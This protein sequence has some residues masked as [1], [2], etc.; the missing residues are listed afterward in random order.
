MSQKGC[1]LIYFCISHIQGSVA[2]CFRSLVDV[3]DLG[4][5]APQALAKSRRQSEPRKC[6]M[7]S[8][9]ANK[10]KFSFKT[11]QASLGVT[12]S[13]KADSILGVRRIGT[14]RPHFPLVTILEKCWQSFF[15]TSVRAQSTSWFWSDVSLD[16]EASKGT[17]ATSSL[18]RL[19]R[20]IW[21]SSDFVNLIQASADGLPES[22]KQHSSWI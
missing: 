8:G 14:G 21:A 1:Q 11:P 2:A 18:R 19:N 12:R 22:E 3:S 16:K 20:M 9:L 4:H 17:L 10:Y 13:S 15:S 5:L 6:V 7:A